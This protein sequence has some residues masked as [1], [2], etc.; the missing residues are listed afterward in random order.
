MSWSFIRGGSRVRLPWYLRRFTTILDGSRSWARCRS[1]ERNLGHHRE[2][3]RR[4]AECT[5][6]WDWN[7]GARHALRPQPIPAI[8][9]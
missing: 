1:I 4:T 3:E 6:W 7:G 9:R 8:A 2:L 5:T